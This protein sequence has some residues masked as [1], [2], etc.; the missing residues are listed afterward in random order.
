[1]DRRRAERLS[2]KS[3][4]NFANQIHC[5]RIL[6]CQGRIAF[7]VIEFTRSGE[8]S[9]AALAGTFLHDLRAQS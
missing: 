5:H 6:E 2:D 4:K 8:T 3:R 1:M 7:A 9:A